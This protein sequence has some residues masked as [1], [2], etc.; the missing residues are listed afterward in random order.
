MAW[1]PT[2]PLEQELA[3]H[4]TAA[5]ERSIERVARAMYEAECRLEDN[6]IAWDEQTPLYKTRLKIMALAAVEA[7]RPNLVK[8]ED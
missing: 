8:G 6:I 4:I 5:L 1:H 2:S 3:K 7:L